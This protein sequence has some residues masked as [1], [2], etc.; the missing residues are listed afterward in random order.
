MVC[1]LKAIE[2]L[3]TTVELRG[4]KEVTGKIIHVDGY[5]NITMK[6][7]TFKSLS[8]EKKFVDFFV[9]GRNIRYVHIPDEIDM[10]QAMEATIQK[11]CTRSANLRVNQEIKDRAWEKLRKK[12]NIAKSVTFV[13]RQSDSTKPTP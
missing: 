6:Y 4:E 12:E 13:R 2:G 5:M 1:L 7:V 10:K 8:Q 11:F 9:N 3:E